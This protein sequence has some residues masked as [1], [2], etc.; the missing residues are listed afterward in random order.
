[1][2]RRK[3]KRTWPNETH[4][5]W[6]GIEVPFKGRMIRR[7]RGQDYHDQLARLMLMVDEYLIW[8]Y[9]DGFLTKAQRAI[10][11]GVVENLNN[12]KQRDGLSDDQRTT[13]SAI[14]VE[15]KDQIKEGIEEINLMRKSCSLPVIKFSFPGVT[16]TD[17][18]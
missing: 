12:R 4:E 10:V 15:R 3:G 11:S 14:A 5:D 18:D 7:N 2:A 9:G 17:S 8:T 1:M 16:S 13:I 6:A